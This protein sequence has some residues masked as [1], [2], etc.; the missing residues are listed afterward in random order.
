MFQRKSF[1]KGPGYRFIYLGFYGVILIVVLQAVSPQWVNSQSALFASNQTLSTTSTSSI[2]NVENRRIQIPYSAGQGSFQVTVA[3]YGDLQL[4]ADAC[5]TP[6]QA[7]FTSDIS[8]LGINA[9]ANDQFT[10]D[11]GQSFSL[12]S[13]ATGD[14]SGVSGN[15]LNFLPIRGFDDTAREQCVELGGNPDD[16]NDPNNAGILA[17]THAHPVFD[18]CTNGPAIYRPADDWNAWETKYART[19]VRGIQIDSCVGDQV[20]VTNNTSL[21]NLTVDGVTVSVQAG[22]IFIDGNRTGDTV[23]RY[24]IASVSG[25]TITFVNGEGPCE[26]T[27]TGGNRIKRDNRGISTIFWFGAI[28]NHT[29]I[30]FDG[31]QLAQRDGAT[32]VSPSTYILPV[33]SLT[34][35]QFYDASED[36]YDND[37]YTNY[38]ECAS[39][40]TAYDQYMADSDHS[41]ADKLAYQ[42]ATFT[43]EDCFNIDDVISSGQLVGTAPSYRD[44]YSHQWIGENY[45]EAKIAYNDEGI[46]LEMMII[47]KKVRF[48]WETGA[49]EAYKEIGQPETFDAW[50]SISIYLHTDPNTTA[51]QA[52]KSFRYDFTLEDGFC[53]SG[54]ADCTAEKYRAAMRYQAKSVW[55]GSQ[56]QVGYPADYPDPAAVGTAGFYTGWDAEFYSDMG[57]N[58]APFSQS[59]NNTLYDSIGTVATA[60][61]PWA[62]MGRSSPPHHETWRFAIV[63]HDRDATIET[64]DMPPQSWPVANLDTAVPTNWGA[65]SF[66]GASFRQFD[67]AF[68]DTGHPAEAY[69][70][71]YVPDEYIEGTEGTLRIPVAETVAVG[72]VGFD[73]C[74][75]RY[76]S[77]K[78]SFYTVWP[79]QTHPDDAPYIQNQGNIADWPCFSRSYLRVPL[80]GQTADLDGKVVLSAK[81][82]LTQQFNTGLYHG[83]RMMVQLDHV[84]PNNWQGRAT[85]NWN[86]TAI[87]TSNIAATWFE[88]RNSGNFFE[89]SWDVTQDFTANQNQAFLA[90]SAYIL[91]YDLHMGSTFADENHPDFAPYLEITYASAEGAPIADFSAEEAKIVGDDEKVVGYA[92]FEVNFVDQTSD[93]E[94]TFWRWDFGDGN[95]FATSQAAYKNPSHIYTTPGDY[96]VTLFVQNNNGSNSLVKS[97]YVS[98]TSCAGVVQNCDFETHTNDAPDVD[99]L[100]WTQSDFSSLGSTADPANAIYQEDEAVAH[101]WS[102][103]GLISDQTGSEFMQDPVIL[104][105]G[106][107]YFLSFWYKCG[108]YSA[109]SNGFESRLQLLSKESSGP[110][111]ALAPENVTFPADGTFNSSHIANFCTDGSR[112]GV[113]Q[114]ITAEYVAISDSPIRLIFSKTS[115]A[116]TFNLMIDDVQLR[117]KDETPLV[118]LRINGSEN[119]VTIEPEMAYELTWVTSAD[120]THCQATGDWS[121]TQPTTGSQLFSQT[122]ERQFTYTLTCEDTDSGLQGSDTVKIRNR[123][124]VVVPAAET[125][126]LPLIIR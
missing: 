93:P 100:G 4:T 34:R 37:S 99:V 23:N 65:L 54:D 90:Y 108:A 83:Y 109:G 30:D 94:A 69:W 59:P 9:Q 112:T 5:T 122:E 125:I 105:A 76:G 43:E 16:P 13:S 81:L 38:G 10:D 92:P 87:G 56:W 62:S 55:D 48:D 7:T 52:G 64:F 78:H 29:K 84:D 114:Q 103:F 74:G 80:A 71:E 72:G 57:T 21:T 58:W 19:L 97:N 2:E 8:G 98:L 45:T 18:Q 40:Y 36:D 3:D 118:D 82:K 70:Q 106:Q 115:T 35:K 110:W 25:N 6:S 24:E 96:T 47:D 123:A 15:T 60:R 33:P 102:H 67:E 31:N 101:S 17:C 75:E 88:Q 119:P 49:S 53:F 66:S 116:E 12:N 39:F 85:A 86:N 111:L 126:N 22:D 41:E 79:Y 14:G 46:H 89:L 68:A 42:N 20:V 77:R 51:L 11:V 63:V 91:G 73:L 44:P 113:W 1:Q 50:D 104:E 121:G 117:P 107:R 28:D 27:Y 124:T 61:L 32:L 95:T 120:A 26:T